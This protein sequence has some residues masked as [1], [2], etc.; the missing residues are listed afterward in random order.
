MID[1]SSDDLIFPSI[2][3]DLRSIDNVRG[4]E[5][6]HHIQVNALVN[7]DNLSSIMHTRNEQR[8]AMLLMDERDLDFE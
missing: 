7:D 3:S 1:S 4:E 2:P 6:Q 5:E 8:R